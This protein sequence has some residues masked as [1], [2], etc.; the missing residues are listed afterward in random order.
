MVADGGRIVCLMRILTAAQMREMDRHTIQDLGVPSLVLMERA[1]GAVA[2]RASSPC[3]AG[4]PCGVAVVC[5][6][7]NNGGDGWV[8]ARHLS[9]DRRRFPKVTVF[10]LAAQK[11]C[12]PDCREMWNRVG[13]WVEVVPAFDGEI[14]LAGFDLIVDAVYG[15]GY[16]VSR[17]VK[18][19]PEERALA[20]IRAAQDRACVVAVDVPSSLD[21]TTG[22]SGPECPAACTTVTFQAPKRGMFVRKGPDA[23]GRIHV[24]DIGLA[25]LAE[26]EDAPVYLT[27]EDVARLLPE[28][29]RSTHKGQRGHILCVG[30][31]TAMPGSVAMTA[32][33][34]L[35]AGAGLSTCAVP[36]SI[37]PIVASFRPEVMTVPLPDNGAGCLTEEAAQRVLEML[38]RFHVLALGPGVTTEPPVRAAIE[39]LVQQSPIPVVLDADGLNCLAEAGPLKH[40]APLVLTPHPGEIARLLR[41]ETDSVQA[42]RLDSARAASK[43]YTATVVLKGVYSV[44]CEEGR[45]VAVNST[46]NPGLATAGSG[47]VLTGAIAALV[48][49]TGSAYDGACA[50]AY[51][52]G[53]AADSLECANKGGMGWT[54]MDV[55]ERLPLA[56]GELSERSCHGYE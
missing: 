29:T 24:V 46:G 8:A 48:H 11:E 39:L 27:R 13:R 3:C 49:W 23:S 9:L 31:S 35:R 36:E 16:D 25:A 5:G 47:D 54:A 50:G 21:A 56:R 38:P 32:Y 19:G 1:G 28:P 20:A 12:S 30:G 42:E 15:T 14:D 40:K 17:R 4:G 45:D 33:S 10:P 6:R 22:D 52:H 55:A 41:T 26:F 37:H 34:A 2:K 7:G 53:L 18:P 44:I 43:E 51:L